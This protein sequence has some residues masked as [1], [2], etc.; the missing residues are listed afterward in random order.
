MSRRLTNIHDDRWALVSAEARHA[1]NPATFE[2]PP[3]EARLALRR[4]DAA[5]WLF[6]IDRGV[7]PAGAERHPV[8]LFAEVQRALKENRRPFRVTP[9]RHGAV[10]AGR[11]AI[12]FRVRTSAFTRRCGAATRRFQ[13]SIN[14]KSHT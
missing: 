12:H 13:C 5:K 6:D 14:L 4:G 2:L 9:G 10:L 11:P 7:D 1:A 3:L 8:A